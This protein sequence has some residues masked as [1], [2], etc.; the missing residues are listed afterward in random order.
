[1]HK[2][3][4]KMDL[5]KLMLL[6]FN[7]LVLSFTNAKTA[8][9]GGFPS[10]FDSANDPTKAARSS[11]AHFFNFHDDDLIPA[12]IPPSSSASLHFSIPLAPSTEITS[13]IDGS[14]LSV[15]SALDKSFASLCFFLT[16]GA[17]F[18]VGLVS[19][20]TDVVSCET[21]LSLPLFVEAASLPLAD[22]ALYARGLLPFNLSIT[23]SAT[24]TTASM[25]FDKRSCRNSAA[26][27]R[28]AG[29]RSDNLAEARCAA[30]S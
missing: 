26:T 16:V 25:S 17:V 20:F 27:L 22:N 2:S 4:S 19:T 23:D 28:G 7:P 11:I 8:P 21:R 30:L 6:C 15:F 9:T 12:N 14:G 29:S 3:R 24:E 18:A 13:S 1:M 10:A 5:V